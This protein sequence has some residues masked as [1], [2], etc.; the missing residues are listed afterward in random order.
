MAYSEIIFTSVDNASVRIADA[1][2][3]VES[4]AITVR[5]VSGNTEMVAIIFVT[6]DVKRQVRDIV[7]DWDHEDEEIERGLLARSWAKENNGLRSAAPGQS[8]WDD[9]PGDTLVIH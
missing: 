1:I 4:G 8:I 6:D 3:E 2:E 9:D 7:A 5:A